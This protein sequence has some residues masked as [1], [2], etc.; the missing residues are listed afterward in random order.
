MDEAPECLHNKERGTFP[1]IDGV[2]QP[3]PVPRFSRT[4]PEI[5]CPLQKMEKIL[6]KPYDSMI[7]VKKK[8]NP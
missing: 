7:A 5:Q 8:L 4:V 2:I 3:A 6:T 1:K